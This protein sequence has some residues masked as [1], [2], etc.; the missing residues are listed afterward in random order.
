[1]NYSK[2]IIVKIGIEGPTMIGD[3][4]GLVGY[5]KVCLVEAPTTW[6]EFEGVASSCVSSSSALASTSS[7]HHHPSTS[8]I[9]EVVGLYP[10]M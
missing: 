9:S 6:T 1:M 7:S 10:D 3:V 8:K 5:A 2:E 4:L